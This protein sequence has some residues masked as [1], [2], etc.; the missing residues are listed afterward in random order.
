MDPVT[1]GALISTGGGLLGGLM[2]QNPDKPPES[3]DQQSQNFLG[4][5]P[6]ELEQLLAEQYGISAE[7]VR[8]MFSSAS[9]APGYGQI[10]EG[11]QGIMQQLQEGSL[12]PGVQKAY[13][14]ATAGSYAMNREALQRELGLAE[15]YGQNYANQARRDINSQMGAAGIG[16]GSTVGA[17]RLAGVS[18]D[19][20]RSLQ[21]VLGQNANA[22]GGL[23]VANLQTRAG[24][25][26][27]AQGLSQQGLGMGLQGIGQQIGMRQGADA[28]L[29]ALMS[30]PLLASLMNRKAATGQSFTFQRPGGV[31]Q[32]SERIAQ[33]NQTSY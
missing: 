25:L 14:E 11:L 17:M 32:P 27:Q 22:L 15:D 13:D 23:G 24:G 6:P 26:L 19:V 5:L 28:N 16:G 20:N 18:A 2:G 30:N 9:Q 10:N 21:G 12:T 33:Q 1:T 8:A 4:Q 29:N 31:L 7:A 3:W